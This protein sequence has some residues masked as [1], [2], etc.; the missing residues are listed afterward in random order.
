MSNGEINMWNRFR[1][2]L[3]KKSSRVFKKKD[4]NI[5]KLK[6]MIM[7]GALLVDVRSPQEYQEGHLKGAKLIPE[8]EIMKTCRYELKD[9]NAVIILYCSTGSRSKKAQRKLEKMGYQNVYNLYNGIQNFNFDI[10]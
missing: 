5:E 2:F 9:K 8:Y 7:E 6:K 4:I 3:T 10:L 1:F